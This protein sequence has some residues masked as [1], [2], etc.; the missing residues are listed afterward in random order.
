V[1]GLE[2]QA[3]AGEAASF[4][5]KFV[6]G[7]WFD[8]FMALAAVEATRMGPIQ[9]PVVLMRGVAEARYDGTAGGLS[10]TKGRAVVSK[11]DISEAPRLGDHSYSYADGAQRR[12][13][14]VK[15]RRK[16]GELNLRRRSMAD[17]ATILREPGR[18]LMRRR[19]AKYG[20]CK[21]WNLRGH[22]VENLRC[23]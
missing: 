6:H 19:I 12:G 16:S 2:L 21:R 11:P 8:D 14:F 15:T 7:A 23:P 13:D 17:D 10:R 22:H 3:C 4:G 18:E 20:F 1:I 5:P 9:M